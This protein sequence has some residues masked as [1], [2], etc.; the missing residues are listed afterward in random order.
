MRSVCDQQESYV[1]KRKRQLEFQE[2]DGMF[3]KVSPMKGVMYFGKKGKLAPRYIGPFFII[4]CIGEVAYQLELP[5]S[6]HGM[7]LVFHVSM[8]Q[9]YV[10][11][12]S[13]VITHEPL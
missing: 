7:H 2:G 5:E 11:D 9:K 13:N 10:P 1:N 8:L 6:M 3:L 4:K 12:A